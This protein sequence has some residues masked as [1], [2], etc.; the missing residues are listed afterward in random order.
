MMSLLYLN[1][2]LQLD[3]QVP[4][5]MFQVR[6]SPIGPSGK[7]W[8]YCYSPQEMSS[9]AEHIIPEGHLGLNKCKLRAKDTVF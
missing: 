8:Q 9:Y 6:F 3:G 5:E 1:T 4:S 2:T 7:S